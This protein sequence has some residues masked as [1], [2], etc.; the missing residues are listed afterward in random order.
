MHPIVAERG[1]SF[2]AVADER[3]S[4]RLKFQQCDEELSMLYDFIGDRRFAGLVEVGVASGRTSWIL[5]GLLK[6]GAT[7]IGV[8]SYTVNA[9]ETRHVGFA[10]YDALA[11]EGFKA[12]LVG[13]RSV[14]ALPLVLEW[15]AEHKATID[16]LHIDGEHTKAAVLRDLGLYRALVQKGGMIQFHD[17]KTDNPGCK[18]CDAWPEIKGMFAETHEFL[19][20]GRK[21]MGIG[22]VQC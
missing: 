2:E 14:D 3:L 12:F 10:T 7:V 16:Y 18:V 19:A 5:A 13:R 8:D 17:I 15:V 4:D 22:L 11:A 9:G 20:A 21:D 1:A 6:S